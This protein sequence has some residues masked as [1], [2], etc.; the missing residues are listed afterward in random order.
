MVD[1]WILKNWLLKILFGLMKLRVCIMQH[2]TLR[3]VKLW[4]LIVNGSLIMKR[5][6]D[7]IRFLSC[8][9]LLRRWFSSLT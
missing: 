9:L 7:L 6:A 1:I 5:E 8:K 2:A 4:A 3:I